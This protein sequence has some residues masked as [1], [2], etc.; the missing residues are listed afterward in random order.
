MNH[1]T[2]K[3]PQGWRADEMRV[4]RWS[5]DVSSLQG[6]W[7]KWE[8]V[9]SLQSGD[10]DRRE[11]SNS[12]THFLCATFLY[13]NLQII[14]KRTCTITVEQIFRISIRH[15]QTVRNTRELNQS[16]TNKSMSEYIL[17]RGLQS[18]RHDA[19]T[20]R[21]KVKIGLMVRNF[22]QSCC[23]VIVSFPLLFMPLKT[24]DSCK[25][26]VSMLWVI[27]Y[28]TTSFSCQCCS[29]IQTWST[30]RHLSGE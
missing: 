10:V 23:I 1:G 25:Y 21:K 29:H 28:K 11:S 8:Q 5:G 17:F 24:G 3:R 14:G 20:R 19:E 18:G 12:C 13:V 26:L 4:K 16:I 30:W 2:V 6:R 27:K 15:F 9:H 22:Y 7:G